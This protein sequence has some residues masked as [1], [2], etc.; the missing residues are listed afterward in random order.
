MI[1][2]VLEQFKCKNND[3]VDILVFDVDKVLNFDVALDNGAYEEF[4]LSAEDEEKLRVLLNER[5]ESKE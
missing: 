2:T 3:S 1:G 5:K 4:Y